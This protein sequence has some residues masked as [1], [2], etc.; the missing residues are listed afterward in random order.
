MDHVTFSRGGE[1]HYVDGRIELQAEDGGLVVL[2]RDGLLWRILPT[3]I[4]SRTVDSAPFRGLDKD[5]MAKR[6]LAALPKDFNAYHTEHYTIFYNGSQAYAQWCGALFERLFMAFRNAWSRQGFEMTKPEVRLVAV[7]F[8]DKASYVRYSEKA[9]GDAADLIFGYYEPETTNRIIMYDLTDPGVAGPRPNRM[10][11]SARFAIPRQ[12]Q[13]AGR[14]F[15]D[16]SR[17]DPPDRLQ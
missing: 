13:R 11:P 17:S 7:V 15:H 5:E 4:V 10:G 16:R 8:A 1:Q 6:T 2:G 12:P 9:L 3:E 14:R